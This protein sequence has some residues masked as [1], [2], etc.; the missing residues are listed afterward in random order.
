[1]AW[2]SLFSNKMAFIISST[3]QRTPIKA[4]RITQHFSLTELK[5]QRNGW[6]LSLVSHI[7]DLL[8]LPETIVLFWQ[9]TKPNITPTTIISSI[10]D[11]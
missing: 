6:M 1:M 2:L 9:V 3:W 7:F 4:K 5:R 10:K 8:L 11:L